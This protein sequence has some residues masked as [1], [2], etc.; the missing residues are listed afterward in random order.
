MEFDSIGAR[1]KKRETAKLIEQYNNAAN[2]TILLI[3][4]EQY[5]LGVFKNRFLKHLALEGL[6]WEVG[7]APQ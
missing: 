3:L 6:R 4:S 1:N 7:K 5:V 2:S